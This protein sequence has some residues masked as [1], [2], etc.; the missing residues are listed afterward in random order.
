MRSGRHGCSMMAGAGAARGSAGM[1]NEQLYL[2]I[3]IP[4]LLGLTNITIMLF[5]FNRQDGRIDRLDAKIDAT[6][7]EL[8]SRIDRVADATAHFYRELD[9]HASAIEALEKRPR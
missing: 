7:L 3:G 9:K 8:V 1:T 6:R 5:M 2:S 4:A